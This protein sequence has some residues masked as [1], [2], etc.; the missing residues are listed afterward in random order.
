MLVKTGRDRVADGARTPILQRTRWSVISG[1]LALATSLA[2]LLVISRVVDPTEYGR[3]AVV[4]AGWGL[5]TAPITWPSTVIMRFGPVELQRSESL[6]QT[7]AARMVFALPVLL[8]LFA[9]TPVYLRVGRGWGASMIALTLGWLVASTGYDVLQWCSTASQRFRPAALANVVVKGAPLAIALPA[10]L[11]R[12]SVSS[13]A[14]LQVTVLGTALAALVLYASMRDLLGIAAVD[15]TLVRDMWRYARPVLVGMPSLAAIAWADPLIL[16]HFGARVDVGHYQ[17]AT[18]TITIF[19]TLGGSL[20]AVHSP[21]LVAA[22]AR[23]DRAV[24][25]VYK[26]RGQPATALTFG[27]GAFGAACIAPPIVRAVLS[28]DYSAAGDIVGLLTAAGGFIVATYSLYPIFMATDNVGVQQASVVLQAMTNVGFDV[29]LGRAEGPIGIA[30]ANVVAWGV[31][32]LS[33]NYM[34]ARRGV[35]QLTAVLPLLGGSAIAVAAL[36]QDRPSVRI[37]SAVLLLGVAAVLGF[38][39]ARR[40]VQAA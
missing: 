25:D 12:S 30:T 18:P 8:V 24:F 3:V 36:H 21:E 14:L 19:A 6:R 38:R 31:S 9:G 40:P 2:T 1:G 16:D 7:V 27:F 17:L 4:M 23:D 35:A 28:S 5:L 20:N 10:L 11:T 26:K 15:R 32:Y 34:L 22:K 37:A 29:L 33:L 13:E 39:S